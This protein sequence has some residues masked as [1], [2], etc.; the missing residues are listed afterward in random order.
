MKEDEPTSLVNINRQTYL[1]TEEDEDVS[2]RRY[3]RS[4]REYIVILES[5]ILDSQEL[6]AVGKFSALSITYP[7]FNHHFI[8]EEREHIALL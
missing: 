4:H 1:Q 7:D 8:S 6:K 5:K 2:Q 3:M